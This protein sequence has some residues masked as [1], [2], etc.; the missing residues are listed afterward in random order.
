MIPE[1]N[2]RAWREAK[3]LAIKEEGLRQCA[4]IRVQARHRMRW[5]RALYLCK[6]GAVVCIQAY[7]RRYM[8]HR[9]YVIRRRQM[10]LSQLYRYR[11][12]S[13]YR[14]QSWLRYTQISREYKVRV[15]EERRDKRERAIAR[16]KE[17]HERRLTRDRATVFR[18]TKRMSGVM[19]CM[20]IERTD[21][22]RQNACIDYGMKLKVF[23]P[24]SQKTY[25]FI[26]DDLEVR[27]AIEGHVGRDGLSGAEILNPD[28]IMAIADRLLVRVINGK[29]VVIFFAKGPAGK[30]KTST[31]GR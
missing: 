21:P 17:Q 29:P 26:L 24:Q 23:V 25:T 16:R 5:Y 13:S 15:A 1:M 3:I 14:L 6:F 18:R 31:Q 19:V 2:K 27:L 30:R 9:F 7:G 28:N 22:S 8:Y 4:S 12:L 20:R 11:I 10:D